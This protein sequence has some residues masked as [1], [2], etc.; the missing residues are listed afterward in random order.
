M[1]YMMYNFGAL[2][3][4]VFIYLICDVVRLK[5]SLVTSAHFSEK[6]PSRPMQQL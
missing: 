3:E 2:T 5:I 1:N 6:T 4:Y